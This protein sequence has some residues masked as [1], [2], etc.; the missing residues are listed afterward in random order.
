MW[1]VVCRLLVG[2]LA[3]S[4]GS[5]GRVVVGAV[6]VGWVGWLR[7]VTAVGRVCVRVRVCAATAVGRVSVAVVRGR[8][9][10]SS[11]RVSVAVV[12]RAVVV[13]RSRAPFEASFRVAGKI[14]PVLFMPSD[15]GF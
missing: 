6:G 5:V 2:R 8:D 10:R 15:L 4:V 11:G 9:R 13:R 12:G 7:S 3:G 1:R 14:F